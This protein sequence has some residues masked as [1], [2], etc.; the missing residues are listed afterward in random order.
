MLDRLD[1]IVVEAGGRVYLA[2][3]SRLRPELLAAMY[4]D[5]ALWQRVRHELDPDGH[6]RSDLSRRLW[7]LTAHRADERRQRSVRPAMKDALGNVQSILVLGGA[8]DLGVAIAR[9][10]A[11]PR[12]AAVVLAGRHPEALDAAA[13]SLRRPAPAR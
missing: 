1:E 7:T 12:H 5:L 2:K 11:R 8:S 9:R 4:P 13:A 10:L 6:L 3:D